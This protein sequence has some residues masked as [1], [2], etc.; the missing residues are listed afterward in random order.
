MVGTDVVFDRFTGIS[1]N[2]STVQCKNISQQTTLLLVCS[3]SKHKMWCVPQGIEQMDSEMLQAIHSKTDI[4]Q[5]LS[6]FPFKESSS[7]KNK[8]LLKNIRPLWGRE[9]STWLKS[10]SKQSK[11]IMRTNSNGLTIQLEKIQIEGNIWLFIFRIIY[12][13]NTNTSALELV[14][15]L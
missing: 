11:N 7:D 12:F 2:K 10:C 9:G 1:S 13:Q 15:I 3:P 6:K 5:V 4:L 14:L 8:E